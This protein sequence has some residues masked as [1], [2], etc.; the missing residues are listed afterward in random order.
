MQRK[1]LLNVM[2]HLFTVQWMYQLFSSV[3]IYTDMPK[4]RKEEFRDESIQAKW[5]TVCFLISFKLSNLILQECFYSQWSNTI[6]SIWMWCHSWHIWSFVLKHFFSLNGSLHKIVLFHRHNVVQ[7]TFLWVRCHV[8][9]LYQKCFLKKC[10][11][12]VT[13][14]LNSDPCLIQKQILHKKKLFNSFH[15]S[16]TL[17]VGNRSLP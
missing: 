15:F 11:I 4:L 1:P 12:S 9:C 13:L 7:R 2:L 14:G 3:R 16:G 6:D 5:W 17:Q 10:L 8:R